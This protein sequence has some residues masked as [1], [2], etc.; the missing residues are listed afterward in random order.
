MPFAM[1]DLD[2][3]T[4]RSVAAYDEHAAA[5]QLGLRRHRPAS[6]LRRFAQAAG[7]GTIVLDAACGPAND[8][9]LLRDAGVHPIGLDLSH[10]ALVHARML[11]PRDGL[12]QAAVQDPPF[13]DGVF[14]GLWCNGTLTHLPR[15][16]WRA[17][18]AALVRTLGQG[19]VTLLCYRGEV[20]LTEVVDDVLGTIHVSAATEEE[21]AGMFDE[22][23]LEDVRVEVRPDPLHGRRRPII[24]ATGTLPAA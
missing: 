23:G 16:Q 22:R 19:P 7:R 12:V 17:T 3:R 18:F 4:L 13:G 20:D 2:P 1:Q 5:Y 14:G 15:D 9:R 11:L 21:V 8:L 24:V 10:G 6:E